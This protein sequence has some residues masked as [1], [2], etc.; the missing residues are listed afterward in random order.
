MHQAS[1]SSLLSASRHCGQPKKEPQFPTS[2]SLHISPS[3]RQASGQTV[4]FDVKESMVGWRRVGWYM[5][6][7]W[8][9]FEYVKHC[10]TQSVNSETNK[11]CKCYSCQYCQ[12]LQWQPKQVDDS[13]ISQPTRVIQLNPYYESVSITFMGTN[14]NAHF[15]SEVWGIL[16]Y[17]D[18]ISQTS[19]S[20]PN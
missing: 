11:V 18:H 1:C 5:M 8:C 9:D 20:I 4:V 14:I 10:Q 7:P 19:G 13:S 3:W 17:Q 6:V 2:G 16:Q 12:H 15:S